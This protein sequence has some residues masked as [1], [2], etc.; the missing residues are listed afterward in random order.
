MKSKRRRRSS[1]DETSS[2]ASATSISLITWSTNQAW[3]ARS[4]VGR[5]ERERRPV[6][7]SLMSGA[8]GKRSAVGGARGAQCDI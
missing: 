6:C 8:A 2:A 7:V 4:T 5:E 3:C 1:S